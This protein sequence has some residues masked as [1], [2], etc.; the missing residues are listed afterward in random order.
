MKILLTVKTFFF[1]LYLLFKK[2]FLLFIQS[3]SAFLLPIKFILLLVGFMIFLDL[4]SGVWKAKKR[5]EAITSNKLSRTIS[6]M[7]LYQFGIITFF[8]VDKFLL[9]EFILH[10][11][12]VPYLLTKLVGIFFVWIELV[13]LNEN[14]T[15]I[16]GV[17]FFKSVKVLLLRVKEIK[18][19]L[20]E[21]RKSD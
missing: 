21:L 10:F 19:D 6:K 4:I 8:A 16:T 12:S 11:S 17:N 15:E 14:L 13:S 1:N 7:L 18:E 5:G 20:T 9:G 2:N 3:L